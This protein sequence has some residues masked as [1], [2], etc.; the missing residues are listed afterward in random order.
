MDMIH[1]YD[2]AWQKQ[3]ALLLNELGADVNRPDEISG[4]T[5]LMEAASKR[6]AEMVALFLKIGADPCLR[7]K[8]GGRV[9]DWVPKDPANEIRQVLAKGGAQNCEN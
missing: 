1:G 4:S 3:V 8:S 2:T 6:E 5:V 9:L 7:N